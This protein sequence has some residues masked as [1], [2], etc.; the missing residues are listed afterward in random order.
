MVWQTLTD[1][2]EVFY[3][4]VLSLVIVV[5]LTP[6]VGGMARV[7]GVVD[8]PG[9]RRVNRGSVPRLGGVALFFGGFLAALAVLPLGR[10]AKGPL[11]GVGGGATV[12]AVHD[13]PGLGWWGEAGGG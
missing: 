1:N 2:P 3:G 5:L 10:G 6:A 13:L 8:R 7:L 11:L 9:A 12:G 4:A